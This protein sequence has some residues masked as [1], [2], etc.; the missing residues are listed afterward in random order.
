MIALPEFA[1]KKVAVFGLGKSGNGAIR[2]LSAG[3]A[4]VFAWDDDESARNQ[5]VKEKYPRV[6]LEEPE[7]WPWEKIKILMLS[8]GVPLHFPKP[9][10][11]VSLAK[12][13][14]A[15]ILCDIELLYH[16]NPESKFIGVTGTNGKSTTTGL[17]HHIIT[18]AGIEAEIGGNIGISVL[19]LKEL[20]PN[21]IYVIEVSS[22]QLDLL[23]K[24]RF[25]VAV[26]LNVTP[27]HIDRHGDMKGYVNSKKRIFHNQRA[28]DRAII[29]IDDENCRE[30]FSDLREKNGT[31]II[32]ISNKTE[33]KG[34]VSAC[35]DFI[36][37]DTAKRVKKIEIGPLPNLIG[38]HNRQNIAA[39]FAV[40]RSL[41]IGAEK[42]INAVK[43]F[44]GLEHRT[45]TIAEIRGVKFINDSKATNAEAA[46]KAILC[47]ENIFW[48]AGGLPKEGGIKPL[49]PLFPRI[50]H[51]FLIGS[52]QAEFAETLQG[53]VQFTKCGDLQTAVEFAA[54]AA[55]IDG[56][57]NPVVLLSPACASFDQFKNFEERGKR[58]VELVNKLKKK[59]GG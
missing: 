33:A 38:E 27:D 9:H 34:G 39:A 22:Y 1:G 35:G 21:G 51:A 58:F 15:E 4:E 17:I 29:G 42:I 54:K 53:K 13:A 11:V 41:G 6:K 48:I 47:F 56:K 18:S 10:R 3:G 45:Q 37:D 50:K 20:P 44:P 25:N 55:F 36:Y 31:K 28:S 19:D 59:V 16:A 32:T 8:P 49:A 57:K 52:A 5:S 2:A 24:T 14:G 30:I 40:C 26:L 43:S 46:E 12:G 7:K 23:H